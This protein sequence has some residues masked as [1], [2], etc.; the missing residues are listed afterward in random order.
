MKTCMV[1]GD[2]SSDSAADQYPTVAVCEDC[3]EI[4]SA[5][6]DDRD[7]AII[8]V[9]SFDPSLGQDTCHFCDKHIDEER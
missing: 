6:S 8:S 9:A 4:H 1:W 3:V 5:A 2:V 7:P